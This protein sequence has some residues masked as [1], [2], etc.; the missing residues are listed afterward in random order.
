MAMRGPGYVFEAGDWAPDF[1]LPDVL[2]NTTRLYLSSTGKPMVLVFCA[3][4]YDRM[5]IPFAQRADAFGCAELFVITPLT[6]AENTALAERLQLPFAVLAD[7]AGD[8]STG[9][10]NA[11]PDGPKDPALTTFTLGINRR[12]LQVDR[13]GHARAQVER[14]LSCI[15][16]HL[17]R[18]EPV[19]TARAAPVLLVPGV[20]D[21][22]LCA[23]LIEV[24]E[25]FGNQPTGVINIQNIKGE[26]FDD[27]VKIR[28]DHY[29]TDRALNARLS[30]VVGRRL[31]PEIAKVFCFAATRFEEFKIGCYN[32]DTGGYFRPHRDN[33]SQR[34]AHRRFAMSLLL[35]DPTEYDGGELRF[36]EYG[37][38]VYRPC[39]GEAV[40]FSC[41][42]LHEL[43][44]VTRG[45]RFVLL[46]FLFGEA[47]ERLRR[48]RN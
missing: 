7:G 8:V 5:L 20:L 3:R 37:P 18:A 19:P 32:A 27:D 28:R 33:V 39:A 9:Y 14:A 17:A 46:A 13:D 23:E 10:R 2:G 34:T 1:A 43:M 16:Q 31:A 42:L 48:S 41:S 12:I 30:N 47:E 25:R 4:D 29:I 45:R 21:A 26:T 44:E 36:P 15:E 11:G 35:N 38:E 22:A 40:V 6:P 24:W